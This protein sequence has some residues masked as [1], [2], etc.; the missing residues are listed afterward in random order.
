MKTLIASFAFVAVSLAVSGCSAEVDETNPSAQESQEGLTGALPSDEQPGVV[1]I[2]SFSANGV[3]SCTGE[4]IAPRVVLTAAHC[5]SS[6]TTL[7]RVL[8]GYDHRATIRDGKE[9]LA[10]PRVE[11]HEKWTGDS[12]QGFDLAV[13]QLEK[14]LTSFSDKGPFAL[15]P[16][17][18]TVSPLAIRRTALTNADLKQRIELV[19]YGLT[20]NGVT[21]V[22]GASGE[23]DQK[24]RG[25]AS[26]NAV[27]SGHIMVGGSAEQCP[28]DSG[29]PVLEKVNGQTRIV[30][31]SSYSDVKTGQLR[32]SRGM[33]TR[34]D[35]HAAWIDAKVAKLE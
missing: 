30:A 12:A 18:Y 13:V 34:L 27:S 10:A 11:V 24:R 14:P 1:L 6:A 25:A 28:G 23:S 9:G 3:G 15:S 22:T 31:I 8:P 26:I 35:V 32:C 2:R 21:G 5:F 16:K 33:N 20:I 7:V 17:T 19:G 29:G 4:L